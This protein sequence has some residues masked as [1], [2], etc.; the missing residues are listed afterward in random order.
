MKTRAGILRFE[1]LTGQNGERLVKIKGDLKETLENI[2]EFL[3]A[4]NKAHEAIR[5]Q[6]LATARSVVGVSA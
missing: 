6:A 4:N 1:E 2:T 3:E 5:A